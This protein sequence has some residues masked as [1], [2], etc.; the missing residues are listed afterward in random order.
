MLTTHA[1]E[2]LL[3]TYPAEKRELARRVYQ[4]FAEGDSTEFFTQLFLVLDVYAHYAERVPQAVIEANQ[5]AQAQFT[6]LRDEISLLAQTIDKR[7][8]NISNQAEQ[9]E[10]LCYTTQA[11]TGEIITRFDSLLKSVGS[12]IDTKAIV[13]GVRQEIES[14][15]K[16]DIITPFVSKTNELAK[17]VTPAL[18]ELRAAADD[19]RRLWPKH[20]WQTALLGSAAI[21]VALTVLITITLHAR[22]EDKF[23]KT[24][25]PKI[26]AAE[27]VITQNQD[28]FRQLANLR[29]PIKVV[30][31]EN[32]HGNSTLG[33][34]A[35]LLENASGAE[36]RTID[37]HY[38]GLIL[39]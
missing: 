5:S 31:I 18:K 6:R 12:Q 16:R 1:F 17:E 34:F 39:L 23:A 8:L 21:V 15:L 11:R 20:I 2:E 29:V 36:T 30:R 14:G 25:A 19:A 13:G 9:V 37:G 26:V 10:K 35:I 3:A 27:K 22:F 7:N 32:P 24:V 4:R 33:E 38:Y 28:A